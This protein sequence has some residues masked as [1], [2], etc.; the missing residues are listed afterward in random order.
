M[1][2]DVEFSAQPGALYPRFHVTAYVVAF[3]LFDT[4]G[5]QQVRRYTRM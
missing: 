2:L 4:G 3:L 5:L 1:V